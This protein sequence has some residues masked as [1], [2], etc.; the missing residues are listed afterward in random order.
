MMRTVPHDRL[1]E[2]KSLPMAGLAFCLT[3]ATGAFADQE[4]DTVDTMRAMQYFLHKLSLSVNAEN[5]ELADFYAHE[6]EE[7]IADAGQIGSYHGHPIGELTG[8]MLEPAFEA[9]EAV[10]ASDGVTAV[11]DQMDQLVKACNACHQATSYDYIQIVLR[12][13]N[14]YLQSFSPRE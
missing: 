6:L 7:S 8:A 2:M 12:D 3:V 10:L 14:P 4:P 1:L 13:E 11:G 5:A 9:F